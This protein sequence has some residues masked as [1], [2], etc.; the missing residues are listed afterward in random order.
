MEYRRSQQHRHARP[1]R[2]GDAAAPAPAP[3]RVAHAPVYGA[4]ALLIVAALVVYLLFFSER[5]RTISMT[6]TPIT[7]A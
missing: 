5:E 6:A 2:A 1:A 3:P 7:A 4:D